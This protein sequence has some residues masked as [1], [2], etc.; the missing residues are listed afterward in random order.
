MKRTSIVSLNKLNIISGVKENGLII[1]LTFLYIL[2]IVLGSIFCGYSDFVHSFSKSSLTGF[3]DLRITCNFIKIF[4]NSFF[5]FLIYC[6]IVFISGTSVVGTI[7][8]PA[9]ILLKGISFGAVCGYMYLEYSLKGIAFNALI[10]IPSAIIYVFSLII[11]S[12]E[13]TIFSLSLAKL[14]S[15]NGVCISIYNE[16]KKYFIRFLIFLLAVFFASLIDSL[17]SIWLIGYFN[18]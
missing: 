7:L 15:P 8:V 6:G 2:G 11:F 14:F 12:R 16:F 17:M 9:T 5:N 4:I 10:Y 18:F 3:I 13:A 1:T